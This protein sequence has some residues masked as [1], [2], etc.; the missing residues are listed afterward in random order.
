VQQIV[1]RI[2]TSTGQL[3]G[4]LSDIDED[5]ANLKDYDW[6]INL[7]QSEDGSEIAQPLKTLSFEHVSFAYPANKKKVLDDVSLTITAGQHIAIVGENGAG[8]S[9]FI[10]LLLGAYRPTK[11][12]VRLNDKPLS[13]YKLQSWHKQLAVLLQDYVQYLSATLGDNVRYGDVS[14][15][16][17]KAAEQDALRQAEAEGLIAELPHGLATGASAWFNKEKGSELSGGQWQ[18]VALAR[19][20]YRDA[21]IIILDEPTSAIDALAEGKIFKRLF[22]KNNQ[23]TVITISHRLTTVEKADII[24]VFEHGKIVEQGVHSDLV[25]KKG[26]YWNIFKD[27]LRGA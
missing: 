24:Y 7:A 19:N 3:I 10:K 18:R 20:F 23:K 12:A 17:S 1:S 22:A 6:F 16:R 9:T 14:K 13:V 26:A 4:V 2:F 5:L 21:P 15:P 27:Q 8:K 11:G 25:A